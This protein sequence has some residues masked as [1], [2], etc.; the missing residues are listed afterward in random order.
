MSESSK[1]S[2]SRMLK[3]LQMFLT[4]WEFETAS[5]SFFSL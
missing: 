3:V 5:G 2:I 4:K 1:S